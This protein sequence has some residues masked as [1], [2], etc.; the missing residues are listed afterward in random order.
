MK[1]LK[2]FES[3]REDFYKSVDDLESEY[4]SKKKKL[5]SEAKAKVDDFM[6]DLTD[7]FSGETNDRQNVIEQDDLSVWY[8]LKC[9][10]LLINIML[11]S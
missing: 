3:F 6:F 4:K 5:F 10:N 8:H 1:W 11:K 9:D 2:L 7:D